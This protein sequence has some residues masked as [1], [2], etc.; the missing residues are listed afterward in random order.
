MAV[1]I[2]ISSTLPI[3]TSSTKAVMRRPRPVS[4]MA[5]TIRPAVP[6]AMAMPIMLRASSCR[7]PMASRHPSRA[8]GAIAWP[9]NQA[10]RGRWVTICSSVAAAAQNADRP[11][12]SS[13][14]LRHHTRMP[15]G[16][17]KCRP[18][19]TVGHG[20]GRTGWLTSI[21]VGRSGW[22]AATR[23]SHMFSA[24]SMA[25]RIQIAAAPATACTPTPIQ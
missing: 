11:A 19:R 24:T 25:S 1:K 10:V 14:T 18:A 9:R 13:S 7:P 2:S 15:M 16:M 20:S 17:R 21:S 4:V 5:P 3:D 22:R 12:D 6:H 23:S 8:A